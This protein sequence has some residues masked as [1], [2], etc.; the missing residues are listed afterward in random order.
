MVIFNATPFGDYPTDEPSRHNHQMIT[1]K[2][3]RIRVLQDYINQS[4]GGNQTKAAAA[5][6]KR[7]SQISDMLSGRKSF[8]EK[9]CSTMEKN[10]NLPAGYFS[11]VLLHGV[12]LTRAG[13]LMASEWEKLDVGDRI[14]IEQE[15]HARVAKKVRAIRAAESLRAVENPKN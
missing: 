4:H 13:A 12:A 6:G 10:A 15:I 2:N 14:E 8:G 1:L 3:L 5:L 9:V 11:V 7:Q